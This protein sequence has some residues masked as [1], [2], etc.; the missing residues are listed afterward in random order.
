MNQT[1]KVKKLPHCYQLP[2]RA[3]EGSI[4]FDAY[5]AINCVEFVEKGQTKLIPLGFCI[6]L[7]FPT[8]MFVMPRSGLSIKLIGIANSPGLV[9]PDYRD[10][11]IAIVENRGYKDPQTGEEIPF[12]IERGDRVCQ[13]LFVNALIPELQEVEELSETDRTG[14]FGSTGVK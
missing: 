10:E 8:G 9:D 14:G 4:G 6:E 5:A 1:F 11:V 13:L 12:R 3:T 7:P 2:K